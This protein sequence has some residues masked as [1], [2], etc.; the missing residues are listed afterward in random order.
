MDFRTFQPF[1]YNQY[2]FRK[3]I[4]RGSYSIVFEVESLQYNKTFAA[5]VT[6]VDPSQIVSKEKIVDTEL[7][8]LISLDDPCII[9]IYN[10]F[11]M[12]NC[13]VLILENC[14]SGTLQELVE[15]FPLPEKRIFEILSHLVKSL[16]YCHSRFIAHRDIKPSNIFLDAYGR[17]KIG[18]FGLSSI[19][20]AKDVVSDKCGSTIFAAPEIFSDTPYSPFAADVFA[21][22][23]TFYFTATGTY[24]WSADVVTKD[25]IEQVSFPSRVNPKLIYL[26][27]KMID[28]NP[29]N[30]PSMAE[31]ARDEYFTSGPDSVLKPQPKTVTHSTSIN[32]NMSQVLTKENHHT[33]S[34]FQG[35]VSTV[36]ARPRCQILQARRLAKRCNSMFDSDLPSMYERTLPGILK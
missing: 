33:L 24:P 10:Y 19:V 27:R 17:P 3:L 35:S 8:A 13:L 20:S 18:D 31:V 29:N 11:Y 1:V 36:Q 25:D 32:A 12:E 22:G 16:S 2:M 34:K 6:P 9:R 7:R 14:P 26:I 15:S 30:R 28:I 21:L 23:V 5:K 4:G